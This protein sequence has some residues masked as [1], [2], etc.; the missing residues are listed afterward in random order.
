[1]EFSKIRPIVDCTHAII[2]NLAFTGI[3]LA[4]ASNG[5]GKGDLLALCWQWLAMVT[6]KGIYWDCVGNG[7]GRP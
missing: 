3:V 7:N 5:N 2:C 6:V 1:M 4:M